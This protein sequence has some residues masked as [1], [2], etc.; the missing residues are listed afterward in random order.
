VFLLYGLIKN[1]PKA[2]L[3]NKGI[4]VEGIIFN[5]DFQQNHFHSDI[6][7]PLI[8]DLITIRFVTLT[9]EW[10][11]AP[12]NQDFQ[13]FYSSQYKDGETVTVYYDKDDPQNFYVVTKQPELLVRILLAIIGLIFISIGMYKFLFQ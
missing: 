3:K 9:Q 12:I 11:T 6:E 8:K 10:I 5:Q 7:N 2:D 1:N 4:K 13:A